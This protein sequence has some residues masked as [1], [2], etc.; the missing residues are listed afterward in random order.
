LL[1]AKKASRPLPCPDDENLADHDIAHLKDMVFHVLRLEHN[2]GRRRP[3]YLSMKTIRLGPGH[4]ILHA[5]PG[6][7]LLFVHSGLSG[8][9][10]CWN[11]DTET[12]LHSTYIGCSVFHVSLLSRYNRI[13][14]MALLVTDDL[15]EDYST[16]SIPV[17]CDERTFSLPWDTGRRIWWS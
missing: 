5:V 1:L 11:V 12:A 3:D 15:V 17:S 8:D 13:C 16:R 4:R 9:V 6:T 10:A 14:S 2:W 7:P